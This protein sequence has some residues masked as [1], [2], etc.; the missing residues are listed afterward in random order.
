[1]A[2]LKCTAWL[3]KVLGVVNDDNDCHSPRD[4][5]ADADAE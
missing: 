4:V 2:T 1:V 5:P 3:K